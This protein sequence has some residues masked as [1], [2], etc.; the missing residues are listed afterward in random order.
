MKKILLIHGWD[1]KNYTKITNEKDAWHNR[2]NF[3]KCLEKKYQVYSLNLPGF[4]GAKEP[5]KDSWG[6]DDY[7]FYI[8]DFI[9][10]HNLK[11]DYLLGYSFGGAVAIRYYS[12][13]KKPDLILISPAIVREQSN[14]KEFIK[15]PSF[16][17]GIREFLRNIYVI[18]IKKTPEMVFGTRFL[19]NTYQ[20]IV[21]E[22]LLKEVNKVDPSKITIIY[23]EED[24]MIQA[25]FVLKHLNSKIAKKVFLIK[26]GGHDIA[27]SHTKELLNIINKIIF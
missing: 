18:K 21:R 17:R 24:Q 25:K 27:N 1:Y 9:N 6:L 26:N 15:T 22:N 5:S 16:L 8:N 3:I 12:L 10:K 13:F 23:G 7:A 4:C 20:K 11:V 19:R 2:K 14:S